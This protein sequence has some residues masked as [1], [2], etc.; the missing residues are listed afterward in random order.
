MVLGLNELPAGMGPAREE[1]QFRLL[2]L[3]PVRGIPAGKGHPQVALEA[4][5]A[6]TDES[7][8]EK[9]PAPAAPAKK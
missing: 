8:K 6:Q 5:H 9:I 1:D 4:E 3:R 2:A 7:L